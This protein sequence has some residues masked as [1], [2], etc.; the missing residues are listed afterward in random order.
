MTPPISRDLESKLLLG[1]W[2]LEKWLTQVTQQVTGRGGQA[3]SE[4]YIFTFMYLSMI[5]NWWYLS[6][7]P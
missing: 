4:T 7:A 3:I 1:I 2:N 6:S 5:S